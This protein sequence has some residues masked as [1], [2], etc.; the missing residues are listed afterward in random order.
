MAEAAVSMS[1]LA[2]MMPVYFPSWVII[3]AMPREM[4]VID[5]G[6]KGEGDGQE[7][8]SRR[9]EVPIRLDVTGSWRANNTF[10]FSFHDFSIKSRHEL[11]D[12]RLMISN[13]FSCLPRTMRRRR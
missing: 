13:S 3:F 1:W 6:R 9:F 4:N 5:G 10:H 12:D 2:F 7:V 8:K 11:R